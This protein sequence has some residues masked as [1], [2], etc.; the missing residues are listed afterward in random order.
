M[1][2][3]RMGWREGRIGPRRVVGPVKPSARSYALLV[4]WVEKPNMEFLQYASAK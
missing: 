3:D 1:G 2:V 4:G